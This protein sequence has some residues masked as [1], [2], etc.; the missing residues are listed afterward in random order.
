MVGAMFCVALATA[1]IDVGWE[2]NPRGE[3]EYII[4]IEP[5]TLEAMLKS[6]QKVI[7]SDVRPELRGFR[8]YRVQIGTEKLPRTELPEVAATIETAA[9][10][11][12]AAP[13]LGRSAGPG[14]S[15]SD[16][17]DA[18][19]GALADRAAVAP[20]PLGA[21]PMPIVYEEVLPPAPP[22]HENPVAPPAD[23][24]DDRF[25]PMLVTAGTAVGLF[26]ALVYLG[27][28]HVGLRHRYQMLLAE[29]LALSEP[30]AGGTP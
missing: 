7:F 30:R 21:L 15:P 14:G 4:Q 6:G 16:D 5:E 17:A 27:W 10:P 9:K 22:S 24:K 12:L 19:P 2:P 20:R 25:V 26:A 28:I 18:R 8:G 3:V 13:S 1:G 23:A 11:P 29:H